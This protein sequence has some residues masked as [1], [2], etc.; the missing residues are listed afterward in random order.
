MTS[1]S[2]LQIKAFADNIFLKTKEY[3]MAVAEKKS[4]R[5]GGITTRNYRE[6][7]RSEYIAHYVFSAFGTSVPVTVGNDI[8]IDLLCNLTDF[9]GTVITVKS[10]S[11]ARYSR[12]LAINF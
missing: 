4:H 3:I 8:G 12:N 2:F 7:F 11:L 1:A 9:D 6:G 10:T 5:S